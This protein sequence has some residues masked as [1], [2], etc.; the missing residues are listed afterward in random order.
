MLIF[1][2][3]LAES[4]HQIEDMHDRIDDL[5]RQVALLVERS[6]PPANPVQDAEPGD[7]TIVFHPE[8]VVG[9]NGSSPA[10]VPVNR[11]NGANGANGSKAT[12]PSKRRRP[13]RA[14]TTE[15]A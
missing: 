6:A 5:Q 11:A 10:R 2:G 8:P 9:G 7:S 15:D 13:P 4:R 1:S 3:D 12:E 14:A